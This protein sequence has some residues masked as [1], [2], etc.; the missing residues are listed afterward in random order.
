MIV[1]GIGEIMQV[2]GVYEDTRPKDHET[3]AMKT[4]KKGKTVATENGLF[5]IPRTF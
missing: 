5:G 4:R 3:L 2:S 1:L